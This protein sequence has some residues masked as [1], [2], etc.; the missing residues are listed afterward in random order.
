MIEGIIKSSAG[1]D[2]HR[3]IVVVTVLKEQSDGKVKKETRQ[4]RTFRQELEKLAQWLDN[5]EVEL[6]AMESTGVYWKTVYEEIEEVGIRAIIVN[7]QHIKKVPGRKTDIG[8]S[9]WI[10]ELARCGLLRASFIPPKDLRQLRLLTRYRL[11]LVG[12]LR[13]EK[14]RL[15]KILDDCGIR[16]G[17]VVSDIDGVSAQQMIKSLILGNES[18]EEIVEL[19]YGRLRNKKSEL[20]L[21]LEAKISERHRDLL[22]R[23]E[24]HLRWL[25]EQVKEIDEKLVEAMMPYKEEWQL[26]QTIPGIDQISAAMLLAEIGTNMNQFGSKERLSSWVGICPG[27]NESAGKKK[28]SRICK[29]NKYVKS[30]LCEIANCANKTAS[31]FKGYYKALAIRRGHKRAIVALAHKILEII[32]TL[33]KKKTPYKDP[34]INY[35]ALVVSRNAPRWIAALREFDYLPDDASLLAAS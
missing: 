20:K 26:I 32:Y 10:A 25:T 12:C 3:E 13:S 16:L 27:N 14:N 2:V 6:A 8:D 31:Q 28:N 24:K 23:I 5:E 1:I 9:E 21:S 19:A 7:A 17:C 33:L 15:H 35:K 18:V 4:Y 22:Q 30:L 29:G 11:R 34:N